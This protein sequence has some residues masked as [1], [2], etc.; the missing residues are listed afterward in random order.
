[1][2]QKPLPPTRKEL[3]RHAAGGAGGAA[4]EDRNG[5]HIGGACYASFSAISMPSG[6]SGPTGM[7]SKS[8]S[9]AWPI[10]RP[11]TWVLAASMDSGFT[12]NTTPRGV[13]LE[14]HLLD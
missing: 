12:R 3:R 10:G 7:K 5:G 13:Q 1:M 2:I 11:C 4:E 9:P 6:A 8:I 14:P